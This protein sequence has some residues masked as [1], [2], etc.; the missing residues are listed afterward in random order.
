MLLEL[1]NGIYLHV[2]SIV[3]V[4]SKGECP[5]SVDI[6]HWPGQ[7]LLLQCRSLEYLLLLH[8]EAVK[9]IH[10]VS[11]FLHGHRWDLPIFTWYLKVPELAEAALPLC[12]DIG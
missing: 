2:W 4:L 10:S 11:T 3:K 5:V 8:D 12:F 1:I 9:S 6:V 7:L